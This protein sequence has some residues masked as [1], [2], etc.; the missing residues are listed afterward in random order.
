MEAP[1]VSIITKLFF[2]TK[3]NDVVYRKDYMACGV[4]HTHS[5]A[6]STIY[7]PY[8]YYEVAKV[9]VHRKRGMATEADSSSSMADGG[10]M[11]AVPPSVSTKESRLVQSAISQNTC[12]Y[13]NVPY[14]HVLNV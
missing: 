8:L 14:L 12:T 5:K 11:A 10:E 1:S 2:Q 13:Y 6:F 3:D 9:L 4:C 7:F